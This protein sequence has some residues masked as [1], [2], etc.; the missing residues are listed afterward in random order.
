MG[1]KLSWHVM[2]FFFFFPPQVQWFFL[3]N[4][5]FCRLYCTSLRWSSSNSICNL[6]WFSI[7]ISKHPKSDKMQ[8]EYWTAVCFLCKIIFCP[9]RF[10]MRA[11]E[12]EWIASFPQ[13]D[14]PWHKWSLNHCKWQWRRVTFCTNVLWNPGRQGSPGSPS[15]DKVHILFSANSK[16]VKTLDAAL[17][18]IPLAGFWILV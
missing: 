3:W 12:Q 9:F 16:C 7:C 8:T 10:F 5:Y 14:F 15:T 2:F 4:T 1:T 13:A 17:K 18:C 6:G 11:V